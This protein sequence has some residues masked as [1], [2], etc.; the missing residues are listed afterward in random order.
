MGE[1]C[2]KEFAEFLFKGEKSLV[3]SGKYFTIITILPVLIVFL[4]FQTICD[5]SCDDPKIFF[6]GKVPLKISLGSRVQ[7]MD[8]FRFLQCALEKLPMTFNL[9]VKKGMFPHEFNIPEN[10][11][12]VGPIPPSHFFGTKFDQE[13]I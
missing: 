13:K 12:Y 10:Q 3:N 5:E 11:D 4:I 6:D 8:S 2:L 1:N 9:P 7:I